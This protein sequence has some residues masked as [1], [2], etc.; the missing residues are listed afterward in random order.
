V[1][2]R[3][4]NRAKNGF[5]GQNELKQGFGVKI[6]PEG[7]YSKGVKIGLKRVKTGLGEDLL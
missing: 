2:K 5:W 3:G 1:L 4:Q 7:E 6:A